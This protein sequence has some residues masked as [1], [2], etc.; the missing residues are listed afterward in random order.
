MA[1]GKRYQVYSINESI[2]VQGKPTEQWIK[3]GAAWLNRDGS[4]NVYLDVLPL[5]GKLH[6]REVKV[7]AQDSKPA[8]ELTQEAN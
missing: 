5:G 8:R 2:E 3:A 1:G 6:V 4:M 7:E